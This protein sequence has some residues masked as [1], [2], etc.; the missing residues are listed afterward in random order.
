[1]PTQKNASKTLQDFPMMVPNMAGKFF[2]AAN[3]AWLRG[4]S[5]YNQEMGKFLTHR[6]KVDAALQSKL[7]DCAKPMD[8]FKVYSDFTQSAFK[9]YADEQQKLQKVTAEA[10]THGLDGATKAATESAKSA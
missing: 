5:E 1:M 8:A 2:M 10:V 4:L 6:L 3:R 7:A 9:D